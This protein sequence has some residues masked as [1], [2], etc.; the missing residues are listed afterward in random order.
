MDTNYQ[1][2]MEVLKDI[3]STLNQNVMTLEKATAL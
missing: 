2:M 1:L 3:E